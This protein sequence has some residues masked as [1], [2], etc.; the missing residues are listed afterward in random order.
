MS[1]TSTTTTTQ[2]TVDD[3][4]L[5]NAFCETIKNLNEHTIRYA[6]KIK[7]FDANENDGHIDGIMK[8]FNELCTA[9][10]KLQELLNKW[11]GDYSEDEIDTITNFVT[12]FLEWI[13]LCLQTHD[14][15]AQLQNL[16]NNIREIY[17]ELG[18]AHLKLFQIAEFCRD[19]L[20]HQVRVFLLGVKLLGLNWTYWIS[21]ILY[22]LKK[23]KLNLSDELIRY[24]MQT[25]TS[26]L[27][28]MILFFWGLSS[29]LHDCG[30]IFLPI[31]QI[32]PILTIHL[33][34]DIFQMVYKNNK[35]LCLIEGRSMDSMLISKLNPIQII[36]SKD[37]PI[38]YL[39]NPLQLD[40]L[41]KYILTWFDENAISDMFI[42]DLHKCINKYM[43]SH[44]IKIN[45]SND[46]Y[47]VNH[48]VRFPDHGIL[49][50]AVILDQWPHS[51][52][53]RHDE[54]TRLNPINAIFR[55]GF[56]NC[57]ITISTHSDFGGYIFSALSRLL[58]ICDNLQE[59]DR[60]TGF[61]DPKIKFTPCIK[62]SLKL[63]QNDSSC[64]INAILK[65]SNKLSF[66]LTEKGKVISKHVKLNKTHNDVLMLSYN[67]RLKAPIIK[68]KELIEKIKPNLTQYNFNS[69]S[70]NLSLIFKIQGVLGIKRSPLVFKIDEKFNFSD[71]VLNNCKTDKS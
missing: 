13:N 51:V 66:V 42:T 26:R 1:G 61:G 64:T 52:F 8:Q 2:F 21:S 16:I 32:T 45:N 70:Y 60:I 41:Q 44:E 53:Q 63:T 59:W 6:R 71:N 30:K 7:S 58:I 23:M 47:H 24:W 15:P 18:K 28:I 49:S 19:N 39:N 69:D 4:T 56:I 43:Q 33:Y 22:D 68:Y 17:Q 54:V 27:K 38:D 20:V 48:Q 34:S 3:I 62:I 12:Y 10:E 37:D 55:G 11:N 25:D 67:N 40:M 36:S 29:L 9:T 50:A 35:L 5:I 14:I 57:L 46:K 31:F 65:Y